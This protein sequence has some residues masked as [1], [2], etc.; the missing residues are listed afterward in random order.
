MKL[1]SGSSAEKSPSLE[2]ELE[3]FF[4]HVNSLSIENINSLSVEERCDKTT[5]ALDLEQ[6]IYGLSAD[7]YKT[8][9]KYMDKKDNGESGD[10]LMNSINELQVQ[11]ND[12]KFEYGKLLIGSDST[13]DD[14]FYQ[15]LQ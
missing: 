7:L 13:E 4:E 5:I 14:I 8:S 6:K 2:R 12:L 1:Y 11:L 15:K 9:V 10:N 3:G